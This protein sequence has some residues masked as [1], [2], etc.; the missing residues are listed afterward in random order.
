MA[1]Q[2]R[3]RGKTRGTRGYRPLRKKTQA[4]YTTLRIDTTRDEYSPRITSP[5]PVVIMIAPSRVLPA[6][7]RSAVSLFRRRSGKGVRDW[8]RRWMKKWVSHPPGR[9]SHVDPLHA[10][11]AA[12]EILLRSPGFRILFCRNRAPALSRCLASLSANIA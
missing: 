11:R 7:L 4:F 1:L 12:S 9:R 10:A 8:D 3:A 6:A 2:E 5:V